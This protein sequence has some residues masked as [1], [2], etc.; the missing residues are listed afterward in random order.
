MSLV[1]ETG[2]FNLIHRLASISSPYTKSPVIAGIGD[3]AAVFRTSPGMIQVATTDAFIEGYHFDLSFYQMDQVGYKAMVVNLSDIAAMN[4]LPMLATV[5]LGVPASYSIESLEDLYRGL[6]KAA[7]ENGVQ[8]VGGDTTSSPVLMLSITVIGEV[9]ESNIVYRGGARPGDSL[10]VSGS[11]G[12]AAMGLD[13]LRNEV[14]PSLLG[15]AVWENLVRRHLT[16]VPRLDLVRAW[17]REGIRPS[18]LID[19]SDGLTSEVHHICSASDCGAILWES[20]L[21]LPVEVHTGTKEPRSPTDYALNGGDDYELLFTAMP[22]LLEG[23]SSDLFTEIG[24]ITEKDVLIQRTDGTCEPL[25][26]GGHDHF[27][28]V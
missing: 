1:T 4:A 12:E 22:D 14:D 18:A 11:L 19:I 17:A 25:V 26:A 28:P 5:A 6:A 15:N 7:S 10:F 20:S 9:I 21:P 23:M 3:D 2:E 13:L 8:I 24:L 27:R 16:P